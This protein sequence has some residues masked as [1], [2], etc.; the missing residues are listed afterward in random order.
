MVGR[1]VLGNHPQKSPQRWMELRLYLKYGSQGA[2]V[3]GCG[4]GAQRRRTLLL[5]MQTKS[6]LPFSNSNPQFKT[7]R[8]EDLLLSACAVGMKNEGV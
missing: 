2:T 6:C 3:L 4:R 5:C 8:H 7:D 1:E